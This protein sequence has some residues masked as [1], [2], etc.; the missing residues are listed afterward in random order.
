MRV[1]TVL[2]LFQGIQK[3]S[4]NQFDASLTEYFFSLVEAMPTVASAVRIRLLTS[5]V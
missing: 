2:Q 4:G 3:T 5:G 1:I